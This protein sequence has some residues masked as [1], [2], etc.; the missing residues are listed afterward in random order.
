[1]GAA[2][3][4][5]VNDPLGVGK[6]TWKRNP[7]AMQK[8]QTRRKGYSNSGKNSDSAV[9]KHKLVTPATGNIQT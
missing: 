5:L 6:N 9:L 1:M 4:T 3:D 8:R 2:P 7:H